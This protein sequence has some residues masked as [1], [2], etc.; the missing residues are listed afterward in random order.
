MQQKSLNGK[1]LF[2]AFFNSLSNFPFQERYESSPD[3]FGPMV[4]KIVHALYND[5]DVLEEEPILEWNASLPESAPIRW[6]IRLTFRLS[7]G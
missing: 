3:T 7:L 6:V 2:G 4:A 1:N 5:V